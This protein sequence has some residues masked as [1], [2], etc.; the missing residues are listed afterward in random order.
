MQRL[1]LIVAAATLAGCGYVGDPLPPALNLAMKIEDL[2]VVEYG[3]RLVIDFTIPALTTDRLPLQKVREVDLRVGK[4]GSPFNESQ[5]AEG[6]K[7]VP[8]AKTEPGRVQAEVPITAWVDQD[9]VIGV[10]VVNTK[11]KAS[12]WSNLAVLKV[13]A[14]LPKPVQ[15]K[16]E[17]DPTGVKLTWSS[18]LPKFRVF[19]HL[20]GAD[21]APA[22]VGTP[23]TTSFVDT[24]AEFGKRY[25]YMVQA[26]GPTAESVLSDPVAITPRDIFPPAVPTGISGGPAVGSIELVWERNT[27]PDLKGYRIYR[28]AEG[29]DF[30]RIA[31]FV[32]APAYS[33]KQVESG[34]KYRYAIT[35]LDQTGNE[36]AQSTP[37]EITAP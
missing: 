6:A 20:E 18:A 13:V 25:E 15:V 12:Q 29:R 35:A 22:I 32:E 21:D 3:D 23:E 33:D 34:K 36:S 26:V 5:W 28:A 31:E 2:R 4:T 14:A 1:S 19:R 8:V 30:E 17:P 7:V 16:A 37:V 9:I 24:A 10:R 27:E 11:G